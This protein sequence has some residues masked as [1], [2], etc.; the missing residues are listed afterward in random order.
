[1]KKDVYEGISNNVIQMQIIFKLFRVII[2]ST[3]FIHHFHLKKNSDKKFQGILS[4]NLHLHEK[5][6]KKG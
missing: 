6:K 2:L 3:K 5:E 4:K 1:M